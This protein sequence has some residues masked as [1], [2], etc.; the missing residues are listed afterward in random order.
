MQV[1]HLDL[2]RNELTIIPKDIGR[3][4]ELK[5]I[6]LSNNQLT[7]L[8]EQIGELWKL[9]KLDLS[10]NRISDVVSGIGVITRLPNLRLLYL[11]NNRITGLEDLANAALRAL[12]VSLCCEFI[13]NDLMSNQ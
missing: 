10:D 13:A 7:S 5:Y 12:D 6:N 9:E 4:I 3:L 2:S 1:E 11:R 8:P